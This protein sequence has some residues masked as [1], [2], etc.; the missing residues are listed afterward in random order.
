MMHRHVPPSSGEPL[1]EVTADFREAASAFFPEATSVA[2]LPGADD[3]VRVEDVSGTWCVRR[4]PEG[5]AATRVR[6][7]HAVLREARQAG[8]RVVPEVAETGA[9]ERRDVIPIAG[10]LFDAVGW[11][12]GRPLGRTVLETTPAGSRVT[13]PGTLPRMPFEDLVETVARFHTATELVAGRVEAPRSP[14]AS[15][16]AAVTRAWSGHRGRL[17]EAAARNPP[18]QRWIRS[19]ERALPAAIAALEA[20]PEQWNGMTVVGHHDLWPAHVLFSRR[21]EDERLTGLVDFTALAAGS[22]LLDLAHLVGHFGGWSADAA[23]AALGTYSAVRPLLPEERRLLPSVVALDLIA[24]AGWRLVVANELR[25]REDPPVSAAL[26][27]GAEALLASLE[28]VTPVVVRGEDKSFP[29]VRKWVH[30]PR[31]EQPSAARSNRPGG[32]SGEHPTAPGPPR[33]R[34]TPSSP[35]A[36]RRPRKSNSS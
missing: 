26:R 29:G 28:A 12:P 33:R 25:G 24:E 14:L 30:R 11:L 22:P 27:T 34:S 16:A 6:F 1:V 23:E 18:V 13:L 21:D 7:V 20:V 2:A 32:E 31:P 17:R 8:V 5:V 19:S 35:S 4:W 15:V 36:P 10:R 3:L 9:G